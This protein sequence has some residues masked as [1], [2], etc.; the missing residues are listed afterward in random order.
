M[1]LREFYL[2]YI[3]YNMSHKILDSIENLKYDPS[4]NT[5]RNVM[6]KFEKAA[7]I[8]KR[9]EQISRNGEI[10]VDDTSCKSVQEVVMKEIAERRVP[11]I[12]ARTLPNGTKELWKLADLLIL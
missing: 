2:G 11:F 10:Y 5:T 9:L 4:K 6:T 1:N 8:G 3:S 12:I 7:V